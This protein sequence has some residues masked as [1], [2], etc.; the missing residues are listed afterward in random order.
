MKDFNKIVK[1]LWKKWWKVMFK[2][3][4]FELIDPECKKQ[5]AGFVSKTIYKLKAEGYIISLKSWVYIIPEADDVKLHTIDLLEKYYIQLLKKYIVQEIWSSYYI[6]GMKSLQFHMKDYSIPQRIYVI[7]R[8][9]NKKVQ[10]WDYEIVFKTISGK[11][12]WKKINLYNK[13]SSYSKEIEV[14]G[15]KFKISGLELSI[16]ESALVTD[17]YE[18]LDISHI[19]KALKKYS[20][21]LSED[22][23]REI[24]KYKYN[25]SFNRLKEISKPLNTDLYELFLD[26]IK[27]NGACFV[28]EWLRGI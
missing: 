24:G 14:E 13:F 23:F 5:Y 21:V 18:W 4:I 8:N 26:I 15:Q 2:K 11:D 10:V 17:I 7:T 1:T 25:M 16:L 20:W 12:Q 22:I 19:I 28:G 3:D 9:L 6:S 27:Q